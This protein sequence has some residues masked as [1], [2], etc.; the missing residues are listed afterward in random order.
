MAWDPS[1][2]GPLRGLN[3]VNKPQEYVTFAIA[4]RTSMQ[5][6]RKGEDGVPRVVVGLVKM[7]EEG[8]G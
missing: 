5:S 7:S 3:Q 1:A 2:L 8:Y 6:S 4:I